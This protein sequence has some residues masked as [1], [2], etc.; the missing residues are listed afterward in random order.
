MITSY[1]FGKMEIDGRDYTADLILFPDGGIL[2]NWRRQSGHVL[3]LADLADLIKARPGLI[4]A[5]TGAHGRMVPAQDLLAA[6]EKK[7]IEL[8][9]MDTG[10]AAALYNR[11]LGQGQSPAACFH[12][13]C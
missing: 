1:E 8:Q 5:G 9:T 7:G 6:L 10:K 13:T 12:L 11:L 2:E 4:I 3:T